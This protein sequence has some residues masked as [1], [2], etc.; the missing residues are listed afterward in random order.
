MTPEE[1][2]EYFEWAI[3]LEDDPN[4]AFVLAIEALRQYHLI[5]YQNNDR[6]I[7]AASYQ[8]KLEEKIKRIENQDTKNGLLGAL[9]LLF[10]EP[11]VMVNNSNDNM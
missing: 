4:P 10:E 2:I 1:A 9:A 6:L 8:Q 3:E 5:P 7:N 11:T